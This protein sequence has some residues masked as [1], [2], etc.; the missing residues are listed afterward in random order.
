MCAIILSFV[1]LLQ[2]FNAVS[3][4]RFLSFPPGTFI[5]DQYENGWTLIR[6]HVC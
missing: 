3:K 2:P 6:K 1:G 5:G 4:I